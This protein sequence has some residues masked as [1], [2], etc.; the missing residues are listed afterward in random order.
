MGLAA[1]YGA[2]VEHRGALTVQSE[3]GAGTEF[4][5]YLPLL[6]SAAVSDDRARS[7]PPGKGL[8]LLVDDEPLVLTAVG[9]ILRSIGYEV[10]TARDGKE[11]FQQFLEHQSK[12]VA[13]VCDAVMPRES[14]PEVLLRIA[15]AAPGLPCLLCSGFARDTRLLPV[16]ANWVLLPK[17]F[18][19]ADLA[20][21]L[22]H[23]IAARHPT[24]QSGR[25]S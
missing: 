23:A 18:H 10:V 17:P 24:P 13:V 16:H 1:V 7:I 6:D 15:E 3:V 8:V 9:H 2:V 21:A 20:Q 22:S 11:A 19:R 12:L 25:A 14:G 5:V 4:R